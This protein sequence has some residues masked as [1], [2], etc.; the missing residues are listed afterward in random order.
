MTIIKRIITFIIIIPKIRIITIKT[1]VT[2]L[3]T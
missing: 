2:K 1:K 3:T